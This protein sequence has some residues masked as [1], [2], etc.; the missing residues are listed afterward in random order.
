MNLSVSLGVGP[1]PRVKEAVGRPGQAAR[2][3]RFDWGSSERAALSARRPAYTLPSAQLMRITYPKKCVFIAFDGAARFEPAGTCC[4]FRAAKKAAMSAA[5]TLK[6]A[7]RLSKVLR[8]VHSSKPVDSE[9]FRS[10]G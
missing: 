6:H 3:W 1:R 7:T 9:F 2:K 4:A 5:G 8:P 10:S